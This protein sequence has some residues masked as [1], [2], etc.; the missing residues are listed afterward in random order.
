LRNSGKYKEI[1]VNKGLSNVEPG[2]T[3]NRRPDITAVRHDGTIDQFEVPSK[4]DTYSALRARMNDNA[5]NLGTR[6]GKKQIV[7]IK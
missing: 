2:I 3:P 4:T 7:P 1:Y 6:A 5:K